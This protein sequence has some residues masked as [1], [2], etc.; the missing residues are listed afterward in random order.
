MSKIDRRSFLKGSA[1]AVAGTVAAAL[2]EKGMAL[3]RGPER[4]P[5]AVDKV[6]DG[7]CQFCQVRCTLK[8]SVKGNEVVNITGNPDNFWTG[9]AMCPKGKTLVELCKSPDRIRYP[10]LRKGDKL[11]RITYEQALDIV[12]EK[13]RASMKEHPGKHEYRGVLFAPLWDSRE[14]E[15]AALLTMKLLGFRNVMAP[16][17]CCI[18]TAATV[19]GMMTGS[20]N[21]STTLDEVMNTDT[22]VLWGANLAETYPPYCRWLKKARD[23]GVEIIFLDSRTT[24]TSNLCSWQLRPRPGSDGVLALGIVRYLIEKNLFDAEYVT[25]SVSGFDLLAKACKPY[26]PKKVQQISGIRPEDMISLAEAVSRSKRCI[27]WMGGCLSRYSNGMQT[28]RA[29]AS[30][31]GITNH[32]VGPGNGLI[33]MQGGKPGGDEEFLE[34]FHGPKQGRALNTR[35]VVKLME[36]GQMDVVFLNSTYRRYPDCNSMRNALKKCG[37]VVYRGLFMC[38]EAE[39]ADLIMPGTSLFESEGSMYGAQRQVVWR[40]KVIEPITEVAE[41]WRFYRDL[42]YRL[43]PGSYP[44]FDSAR[45]LY[46]MAR[47]GVPS[48]HGITLERL[49]ASPSGFTWP[50]YSEN[51]PETRGSMFKDGRLLT[52]DGKLQIDSKLLGRFVWKEPKGSPKG[53][54]ADKKY[55]LIFTQGK[56]VQHWQHTFTNFSKAAGQ[57]SQGRYVLIHPE[58]ARQYG[59]A[60]GDKVNIQS[61]AGEL[62]AVTRIHEQV[63]PGM[64]FTP[65]HFCPNATV[66]GNR[67]EPV[68]S[69]VPNHW[70]R[71]SAQFN[72]FGC[73]LVKAG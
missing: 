72:G 47:K 5:L 25:A 35:R 53:K 8:V 60:E 65:S 17:E 42:G 70:D 51:D 9:G 24:P 62:S 23:K 20:A 22:L 46:E 27:V 34:H 2:P 69:M 44:K 28:I 3:G 57:F 21:S 30:M 19:L 52:S 36:K 1:A 71:V 50:C 29:I 49:E 39:I 48:W 32:I 26:T 41:D 38:E 54:K 16:G 12:A 18:S 59:I 61:P 55:P 7:N 33:N 43:L 64:V 40:N 37:F 10:M 63:L 6:V 11:E 14:S 73:R 31:Q 45:E 13:V 15:L 4:S 56:V 58:T 67:S 66:E 68:N